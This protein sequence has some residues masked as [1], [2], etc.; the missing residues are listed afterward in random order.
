MGPDEESQF[1]IRIIT[2]EDGPPK[3]LRISEDEC[4]R[5][6]HRESFFNFFV[7]KDG[8]I[9][10]SLRDLTLTLTLLISASF[11]GML[12][13]VC[14]EGQLR[15]SL[16]Y[17]DLALPMIS[18]ILALPMYDRVFI[19]L[20]TVYFMGVHQLNVRAH[21]KRLTDAGV[22]ELSNDLLFYAGFTS[23]FS[24]PLIGVF[25]NRNFKPLH[26]LFAGLFFAS[27]GLYSYHIAQIMHARKDRFPMQDAAT[28]DMNRMLSYFM[29]TVILLF[30]IS[31]VA[32]GTECWLTAV[33]E[34]ATVFLHMNY[35]SL[36]NFTNPFYDS[37]HPYGNQSYLLRLPPFLRSRP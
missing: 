11:L 21:Y 5:T 31:A 10:F 1:G 26:Y 23:C 12:Y 15:C 18:D 6:L 30:L 33:L 36:I 35:F 9:S 24:L 34:W 7:V 28:I 32:L 25:D 13:R 17:G 22:D 29:G 4:Q 27:A 19:L 3:S 20:N 37:I 16:T 14:S 2:L 8:V